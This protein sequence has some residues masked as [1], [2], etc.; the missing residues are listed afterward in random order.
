MPALAAATLLTLPALV[1]LVSPAVATA[2]ELDR[3]RLASGEFWRVVTCHWTHWS[4]DHAAWDLLAFVAALTIGWTQCRGRVLVTLSTAAL[5]IPAALWWLQPEMTHYRGLSGLDSALFALV[6]IVLLRREASGG[7]RTL[8][9]GIAVA[10]AAF[11]AKIAFELAS[12]GAVFVDATGFVPV[13]LAHIVGGAVG[14]AV[15]VLPRSP[16]AGP[17]ALG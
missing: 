1:A 16:D 2:F 12:G 8:A 11:V 4:L 7:S 9:A 6:G 5:A 17:S 10:L 13:P 15:A 14:A 3:A